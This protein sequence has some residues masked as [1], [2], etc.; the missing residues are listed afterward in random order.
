MKINDAILRALQPEGKQRVYR[1]DSISGFGVRVMPTGSRIFF[2]QH[3]TARDTTTLGKHGIVSLAEA[4]GAARRIL[5]Q[6]SL[7]H[8]QARSL[9][10]DAA[11]DL[12]VKTHCADIASKY[13]YERMLRKEFLPTLR[14]KTLDKITPHDLIAIM[15]TLSHSIQEHCFTYLLAFFNW[16]IKRS[17][18]DRSPLERM[19]RPKKSKARDR[20]LSDVE[21]ATIW[22]ACEQPQRIEGHTLH[23]DGR[24]TDMDARRLPESHYYTIVKLLLLTGQRRSEIAGLRAEYICGNQINLPKTKPGR[25]HSFPIG[26]T[27][28]CILQ[29][30]LNSA[31]HEKNTLLFPARD[32]TNKP[33]S[34]FS[35]AKIQLNKRCGFSNFTLH[36]ARRSYATKL[37]DLGVMPE[38]IERLLNHQV[39]T[40]VSRI[41]N[42]HNYMQEMRDAVD[43]YEKWFISLSSSPDP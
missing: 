3:G 36:D 37:A 34:G 10:F 21:L 18:L 9:P 43:K 16:A 1:D 8:F 31:H 5:A 13:E 7:G 24:S 2:L 14:S 6:K 38:I 29:S 19:K 39:G 15:D 25:P 30:V 12:F 22:K 11:L 42:R 33:F 23:S 28:I 27:V 40:S 20:V 41:Y 17:L 35:P 26:K 4:R 32:Q